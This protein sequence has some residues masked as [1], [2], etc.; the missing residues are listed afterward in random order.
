MLAHEAQEKAIEDI[1]KKYDG[2]MARV[3]LEVQ[4]LMNKHFMETS[5]TAATSLQF[6]VAFNRILQESGYYALVN[7]MVDKDYNELFGLI[8]EGFAEGGFAIT[9]TAEDLTLVQALK[10]IQS[11]KFSVVGSTAGTTLRENLYRYSLS[12]Y[13]VD[14][15]AAQ[16]A[17]DFAGTNMVRYSNTLAR[18]AISEYQ[19]SVIDIESE[20]LDGVWLYVGVDDGATRDFCHCV[21]KQNAYYDS[22]TKN[23][24]E[25]DPKRKYNC[26]HRLRMV[27]ED[28]AKSAGFTFKSSSS[29]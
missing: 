23:R 19:Q 12:N 26:R 4:R 28:Y 1:L 7:E 8:K 21:L 24:I 3:I 20:G 6:D 13:T 17:T 29:C 9:Y 25:S 18:T 15:M 22:D 16:I 11:N 5:V 14:Q 27:T 10:S 2:N